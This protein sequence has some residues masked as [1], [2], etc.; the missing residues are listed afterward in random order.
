MVGHEAVGV[1]DPM[2]PFIDV[3]KGVEERLP[4]MIILENGFFLVPSGG[5]MVDSACVFYPERAGH[6][7]RIAEKRAKCNKR[8]LT[9]IWLTVVKEKTVSPPLR[10]KG[11]TSVIA[12][13]HNQRRDLSATID[14]SD[15][16]GFDRMTC[17]HR[18]A[19]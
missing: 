9:L 7:V 5:H 1:T 11:M 3:L 10:T 14:H 16:R 12:P 18:G 4:V 8:D 2:I 13:G 6:E 15:I 19:V 17:L